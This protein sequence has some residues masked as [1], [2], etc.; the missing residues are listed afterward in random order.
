M[1]ARAVTGEWNEP[2]DPLG[3][4]V[5]MPGEP[6]ALVVGLMPSSLPRKSFLRDTSLLGA[7]AVFRDAAGVHRR[8]CSDGQLDEEPVTG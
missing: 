5:L 4:P 1:D 3:H 7:G 2:S 6:H 8:L